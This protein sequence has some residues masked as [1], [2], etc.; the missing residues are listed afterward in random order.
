MDY[1]QY[2]TACEYDV[3]GCDMGGDCLCYCEAILG[4]V[5]QCQK[6]NIVINWRIKMSEC[7]KF[8]EIL[9]SDWLITEKRALIG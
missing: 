9:V 8:R 5:T 6:H 3:C 4:Y 7:R 2:Q 1:S